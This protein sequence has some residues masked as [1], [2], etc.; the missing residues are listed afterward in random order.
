[1]SESLSRRNS[2]SFIRKVK[3]KPTSRNSLEK[4]ENEML[5][6][7]KRDFEKEFIDLPDGNKIWTLTFNKHSS[8]TPLVIVHGFAGGVGIWALN[9]DHISEERPVYAMDLLGFGK[10]SRPK[11][12]KKAENSENQFVESIEQWREATGIENMILLGHSFGGFLVTGYALKYPHRIKHLILADPWGFQDYHDRLRQIPIWARA[13]IRI[14]TPLNPLSIVRAAGPLGPRLVHARKDL[15]DKFTELSEDD[16][17]PIFDY[18]Y[19]CN[20]QKPSGEIG[21]KNLTVKL[22]F[23]RY[24]MLNRIGDLQS[25][26]PLTFVYGKDT[27]NDIGCGAEAKK[28]LT[29][30]LV[31]IHTIEDAGHHIY[32]DQPEK[33]HTIINSVCESID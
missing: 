8:K 10:S 20:A 13:L 26:M 5:A 6:A 22:G 28:V 25:G 23:A 2:R 11:F 1:M 27:W 29:D 9:Y 15:G 21:F 31:H 19:H 3:W 16:S 4:A 12:E 14:M 24:P 32:A 17:S 18:I 33:F 7:V 30:S